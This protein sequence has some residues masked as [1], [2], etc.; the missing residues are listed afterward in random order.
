MFCVPAVVRWP[1]HPPAAVQVVALVEFHD[2]TAVAPDATTD[3]VAD[4]TAVGTTLTT[5]FA[6]PPVPPGPEQIKVKV[7]LAVSAPV[8]SL[9]LVDFAPLQPPEAA[10]DVA[11]VELQ[12]NVDTDSLF[13]MT[14]VALI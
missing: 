8:T 9:P 5:T 7:V 14:G 13:T 2:N 6:A 3:G 10:Q 12:V 11:F 4:S 1:F